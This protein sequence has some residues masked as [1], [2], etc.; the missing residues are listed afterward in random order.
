MAQQQYSELHQQ[1][2]RL[3]HEDTDFLRPI[4]EAVVQEALA[5]STG[6][7]MPSWRRSRAGHWRRNTRI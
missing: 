7:L 2:N 3:L 6:R 4:V 5:A 1:V